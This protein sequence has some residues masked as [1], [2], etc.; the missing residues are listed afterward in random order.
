LNRTLH[1]KSPVEKM[2]EAGI[3]VQ[4]LCQRGAGLGF[5]AGWGYVYEF[6]NDFW[7]AGARF[8]NCLAAGVNFAGVLLTNFV[9]AAA[10][11]SHKRT[12]L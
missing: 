5:L 12:V 3:L 1:E 11:N 7:R 8:L 4:T 6:V 10:K 9:S 2:K